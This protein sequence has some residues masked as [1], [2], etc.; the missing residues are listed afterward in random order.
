[1]ETTLQ[2][3]SR[4]TGKKL[5][6]CKCELC[7]RQCAHPC[8]GT[9]DDLVKLIE[10]GYQNRIMFILWTGAQ[11]MGVHPDPIPML[12]PLKDETKHSCTFFTDGLCELHTL[13]LKPTEGKL[14]HHSTDLAK[15]N[16]RKSIGWAV[17]KEWLKLDFEE[18]KKR[19]ESINPTK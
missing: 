14:S 16:P 4:K 3:I 6:F 17:A 9:P 5:S 11:K 10:A 13:G 18:F 19:L 15:F 8:L 2:K 12:T 1:M 7:K